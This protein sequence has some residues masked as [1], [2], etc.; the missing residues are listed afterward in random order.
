MINF[1]KILAFSF[2]S[3]LCLSALNFNAFASSTPDYEVTESTNNGVSIQAIGNGESY[4]K[5]EKEAIIDHFLPPRPALTGN[6]VVEGEDTGL[7]PNNKNSHCET[8]VETEW[9]VYKSIVLTGTGYTTATWYGDGNWDKCYI[10]QGTTINSIDADLTLHL[11]LAFDLHVSG[12]EYI[13]TWESDA[14]FDEWEVKADRDEIVAESY[15]WISSFIAEDSAEM[16]VDDEIYKP[17]TYIKIN[18]P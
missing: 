12:D 15:I 6:N 2:A 3:C 16:Y 14:I 7:S 9:D 18:K 5:E 8:Y 17:S 10:N 11:P 4:S 1:K 13:I